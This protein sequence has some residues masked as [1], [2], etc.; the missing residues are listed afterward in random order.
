MQI[1]QLYDFVKQI[2]D[3]T[4]QEAF[5]KLINAIKKDFETMKGTK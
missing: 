2:Q 1:D 3:K 5:I 4:V